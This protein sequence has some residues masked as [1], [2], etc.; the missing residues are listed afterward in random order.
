VQRRRPWTAGFILCDPAVWPTALSKKS[1]F[2]FSP[3]RRKIEKSERKRKIENIRE[4]KEIFPPGNLRHRLTT[5]WGSRPMDDKRDSEE[6]RRSRPRFCDPIVPKARPR[7]QQKTGPIAFLLG[8][9]EGRAG[10]LRRSTGPLGGPMT[11]GD[12]GSTPKFSAGLTTNRG[13][14]PPFF[15]ADEQGRGVPGPGP[16]PADYRPGDSG[17]NSQVCRRPL[18]NTR[19]ASALL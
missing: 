18:Q 2:V 13:A 4:R 8:G 12:S 16:D 9:R 17:I 6:G 7:I 5:Q 11:R 10:G 15:I 3:S 14:T 1:F 19:A